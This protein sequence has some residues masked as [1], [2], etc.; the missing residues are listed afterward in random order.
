MIQTDGKIIVGGDPYN[1]T[2][3][4]FT[5]ARYNSNG[6]LDSSFGSGGIV[7]TS[8]SNRD[9]IISALDLQ[10]DGKILAAGLKNFGSFN[11]DFAVVRYNTDG[12][13]DTGFGINGVATTAVTAG[14]DYCNAMTLQ[15][16]ERLFWLGRRLSHNAS[17]ISPWCAIMPMERLIRVSV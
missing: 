17:A 16:M 2:S 12:S 10:A 6:S 15:P 14:D 5:L 8:L 4:D 9:D 7:T 3:Y 11:T 13:L 1:G